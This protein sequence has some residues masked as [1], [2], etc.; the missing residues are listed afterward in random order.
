[1]RSDIRVESIRALTE[2]FSSEILYLATR[3]V[4]THHLYVGEIVDVIAYMQNR[5]LKYVDD[6]NGLIIILMLVGTCWLE[7]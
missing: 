4:T 2:G 5:V 1:M 3:R 6:Y 7:F